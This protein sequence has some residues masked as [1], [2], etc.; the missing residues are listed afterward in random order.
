MHAEGAEHMDWLLGK[1][2]GILGMLGIYYFG[3]ILPQRRRRRRQEEEQD[4]ELSRLYHILCSEEFPST[5]YLLIWGGLDGNSDAYQAL[6]RAMFD[7]DA[8]E[9]PEN[10]TIRDLSDVDV[11]RAIAECAM[12]HADIQDA[13]RGVLREVQAD[14][15]SRLTWYSAPVRVDRERLESFGHFLDHLEKQCAAYGQYKVGVGELPRRRKD[16]VGLTPVTDAYVEE[17][18]RDVILRTI[19]P[20]KDDPNAPVPL[21]LSALTTKL[22]SFKQDRMDYNFECSD[23]DPSEAGEDPMTL[24]HHQGIVAMGRNDDHELFVFL[25]PPNPQGITEDAMQYE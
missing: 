17:G 12:E 25:S 3:V 23:S 10:A 13:A 19:T 11:R 1:I 16:S 24:H 15:E 20:R 14:I 7:H 21:S 9:N 8:C 5:M 4:D 6:S 18:Y 2:P 22:Q